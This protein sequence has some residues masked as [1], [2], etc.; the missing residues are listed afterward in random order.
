MTSVSIRRVEG[1]DI[2]DA[3]YT[4]QIYAYHARLPCPS[5]EEWTKGIEKSQG[6]LTYAVY[7]DDRPVCVAGNAQVTQNVRG[8]LFPAGIIGGVATLPA[9]RRKGYARQVMADLLE[10]QFYE[11]NRHNF[12]PGK[13]PLPR[14]RP[15]VLYLQGLGYEM[16]GFKDQAIE[17]YWQVAYQY[18]NNP[19]AWLASQ[20][21]VKK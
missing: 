6:I 17:A 8:R 20:K 1:P 21:L 4:V 14:T 5:K 9:A 7:E 18:P 12:A 11:E 3:V 19:Y 10:K 15:E 13:M 2:A 16:A